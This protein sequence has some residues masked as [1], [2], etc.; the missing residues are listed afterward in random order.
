MSGSPVG[1][2]VTVPESAN[3]DSGI[4]GP[5]LSLYTTSPWY[6]YFYFTLALLIVTY[7]FF[8]SNYKH[9]DDTTRVSLVCFVFLVRYVHCVAIRVE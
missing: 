8:L 7:R 3:A 6:V 2:R 4:Q 9:D 5:A 1:H